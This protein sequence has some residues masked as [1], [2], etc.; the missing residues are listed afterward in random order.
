MRFT[1]AII[2]PPSGSFAKGLTTA[3]LG[4]PDLAA[5]RRQHERYAETLEACGLALIRLPPDPRY[6]DSTFVED[7]AVLVGGI[8]VLTRPGAP[9]RAGEVESIAAI[10]RQSFET[11]RAIEA[12]GTL[13][14]GDV[15]EADGRVFIGVSHR[16]NESGAVQ[17]SRFLEGV[18]RTGVFVDIRETPGILHLKSGIAYLDDN[19]LVAID[20][21]AERP[22]LGGL[23]L[24]RVPA[25]EEYAANCVPVNNRL[26]FPGG[27]PRLEAK[28]ESLG[29]A[30]HTVEMSE[31]RKMDGGL[32]C[33]SL[34]F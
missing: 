28:L 29:Y 1:T 33:L 7:A 6:P 20:A 9:S 13:D 11:I 21:L 15:C 4:A 18:G 34:R 25:G 30:V 2:R 32:S 19:R 8:A 12:P 14:G 22:E 3:D 17:L 10:V 16:T 23:E 27:F 26:L 24:V 5:A 31:F